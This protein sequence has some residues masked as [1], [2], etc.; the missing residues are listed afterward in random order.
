MEFTAYLKTKHRYSE[1]TLHEKEKQVKNWKK[2]CGKN[3]SF[4][5]IT[6]AE[7]LKIV[8][9]RKKK[10]TAQTLNNQ[11]QT[12]EQYFYFLLEKGTRKDHPLKNFR[13]K[14]NKKP[15]IKGLLTEEE[16]HQIY[17]N[18]SSKGHLGGQF[19][20]YRQRNKIIL[21]LMIYQGL[22]SGSIEKL[23]VQDIDLQKGIVNV[24]KTTDF[25][26]N[27][28]TLPLEA[29]QIL[30]LNTY[31]TETRNSLL[32]LIKTHPENPKLI[33]NGDKTRFSRFSQSI[34]RQTGLEQLQ[35]LRNSRITIWLKYHNLREVQYKAGYKSL[36]SLEKFRRDELE[37]LKQAV[38][39]Y[40]PLG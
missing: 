26:L 20:V 40:H 10:Y 30:E 22:N 31:L 19:D 35:T 5:R 32:Q 33:P 14:T 9:I 3:Q 28:R 37:S 25:K 15:L 17:E 16:L 1:S 2:Y 36:L 39:K 18:Y 23:E 4:D 6:T 27:A 24:P 11:L 13:I 7:L 21:G 34:R 8:E 12:L 38:E 29:V